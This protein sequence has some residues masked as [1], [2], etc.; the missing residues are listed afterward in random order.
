MIGSR[1]YL[2]MIIAAVFFWAQIAIAQT[3]V[4]INEVDA[5]TPGSDTGE[6]IELFDGGRG[7]TALDGLVIVLFNGNGD[8]S[9]RA[10]DLDNYSTDADGYFVL[11]S[12]NLSPAPDLGINTR[13]ILQDGPDAVALYR[14]NASDFPNGTALTTN[15][16]IDALVY[17]T[18]DSDDVGLLTL[19]NNGQPQVNENGQCDRENHSNQHLPNGSGGL[20]NTNTY[21]QNIPTPGAENIHPPEN[22]DKILEIYH[23]QGACH[24]S[25]Y[26]KRRVQ[27]SGIV[28]AVASNGFYLQDSRGDGDDSTS[29]GIFVYTG[30]KPNRAVGN[31]VMVTG[32]VDEY[33]PRNKAKNLSVTQISGLVQVD[34]ISSKNSLPS[35]VIVGAGR[36]QPPTEIIDDDSFTQFEPSSDGIDFYESLEGMR[37]TIARTQVVAPSNRSGKI[38]IVP[39]SSATGLN[40]RGGL[41]I[42]ANDFNPERLLINNRLLPSPKFKP[43]VKPGDSLGDV[44]GIVAY[45]YYGNFEVLLTATPTVTYGSI[46]RDSTTLRGDDNHVLIATYNVYNLDPNDQERDKKKGDKDIAKGQFAAIATQIVNNLN[47]PDI[48]ALQEVQDN[49][50][51]DDEGTTKADQTLQVLIDSIVSAGGPNYSFIDKTTKQQC[52]RR[53]G[54]L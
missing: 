21:D 20:R 9:Y 39:Y 12:T 1:T 15:N 43:S 44:I 47:Q 30:S 42:A 25:P 13:N 46:A 38:Y 28:T 8:V 45:D 32:T 34:T 17:H 19:L 41:T 6:F 37:V 35:P 53:S 33:T 49:D 51:S 40:Q 31:L 27:T 22:P 5:D 29:D 3:T 50:G 26:L 16:L 18:G 14:G 52:G 10:F 11:G 7:N 48:I 54:W 36:R 2:F 23:I 24:T 4:F